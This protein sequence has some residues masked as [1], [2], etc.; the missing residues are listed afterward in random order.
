MANAQIAA[1]DE[2]AGYLDFIE[3]GGRVIFAGQAPK[4]D[5]GYIMVIDARDADQ[6]AHDHIAGTP[7]SS[8]A[9]DWMNARIY[10]PI[11]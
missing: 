4:A 3:Y 7:T 6:S 2:V 8:G 10:P 1:A 11:E 5:Y 9:K